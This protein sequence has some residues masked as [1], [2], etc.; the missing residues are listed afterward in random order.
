[1]TANRISKL[2][3]DIRLLDEQHFL[4]VQALRQAVLDL[5]PGITE[6]V[7]YGGLLF[8]AGKPFCGIFAYSKH[9]SLEFGDGAA[10]PDPHGVLEGQG[11]LRRHIKLFSVPD[12]SD[13]Q[14]RAYLELAFKAA[15]A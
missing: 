5:D 13:K 14:V 9:V 12:I 2:L 15:A 3:D 7:K 10:L 11:K 4:L 1:M 8:A 6:E